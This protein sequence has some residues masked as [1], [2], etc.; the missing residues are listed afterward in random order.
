MSLA[1]GT[2]L[3]PFEIVAPLGAGGMGEVYRAKDTRLGREVAVK[4]LPQHLSSNPEIRAR[5]EREAKTVSSLNHPHICTLHDVG[6]EGETDYLVME[7]IEGET[8]AARLTKGAL[9]LADVLRIGAQIAD[10]LGRAHRAG[11]MHRDLK[12]GNVMLTK[13]G[14]KLMDFGLARATGLGATS[15][16]TSS[17]TVA[18]P[19]TA[20]G[21]ILGTFQYMAPEQLEG[22]EADA[23]AD[24]WALG[25]VLYEMATGRRAFEGATQASLI[26]AIM[27]DTP[28]PMA[29][30]APLSPPA[31]ERVVRHCLAKDPEDRI[32]TAHDVKLQLEGI[33]E[34]GS[35][36]SSVATGQASAAPRRGASS[37][38]RIAWVLVALVT[39]ISAGL[40]FKLS[41]P[42]PHIADAAPMRFTVTAP[43]HA[44]LNTSNNNVSI[45]PNGK[46]LA[47]VASDE[48]GTA[49]IWIRELGGLTARALAGTEN[50]H[51]PF[52]S[53]DGRF[54]GF[55]AGGKLRKIALS[56]G[57][58]E[59]LCDAPDSRGG[60][61]GNGGDIVFAPQATGGLFRVSAEGGEP[62]EVV[63]PDASRK[64]TGLRF[65]QFL[66]DGK[67][68]VFVSMPQRQGSYE[69]FL[70]SLASKDRVLLMRAGAAPVWADPDYLVTM[71]NQRLV[72]QRFDLATGKLVGEP[73][74]LGDAPT[75]EGP[76]GV[77]LVSASRNGILAY[78]ASRL[79]NTQVS[80]FDRAGKRQS[81]LPLAKGRW[82]SVNIAPDGRRALVGKPSSAAELDWW[83]VDLG[84]SSARRLTA[85]SAGSFAV[86]SPTGDR[87]VYQLSTSGPSDIYVKPVEGGGAAEPLVV[88]DVLFKNPSQWTPD[89]KHVTFDQPDPETAWDIWRVPLAG[90]RKP[91]PLVKTTAN[92]HGGWVSPDVRWVAYTSDESGR[93]ELY[94]QSYPVAGQRQQLTTSG[95]GNLYGGIT[96]HWSRDGR[97]LL[98][99][100]GTARVM[101]IAPGSVFK[102]GP[103]RL[104][105]VMPSGVVGFSTTT[106]H[107]RFL[108]V[109]PVA[110]AEPPAI[111]LDLNWAA[112]LE[113]R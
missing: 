45:S 22:K 9:P 39:A 87:I 11:V 103:P 90:E 73:Q 21:T 110:D 91:E 64:E 77:R 65:P 12:P 4:V 30:L 112:G 19:L 108:V 25:C 63:H 72:A 28:R 89:G 50:G 14:A 61:W 46:S 67:Q 80:W 47:F 16:L 78:S 79:S 51:A 70:A 93:D 85:A 52:W 102:A 35:Q 107:Q 84:T 2:R 29:E 3:G 15:E 18:G 56:G 36:Q 34:P 48:N 33:A 58:P 26:S 24:L 83:L 17:P 104:L 66:P 101:D 53:P 60:S 37:R 106:D 40:A 97:E 69:I 99:F 75:I 113:K 82:G 98:L 6:R 54:L 13:S 1:P 43:M 57:S 59:L 20:E 109:E 86:W 55:F 96:V 38:E 71:R 5:F 111:E 100:D 23:R 31:L 88:S 10:A 41:R 105:F 68:F 7:L 32:Q 94:V 81:S 42:A 74:E 76:D 8:L 95:I 49:L 44:R 92:E 62:A 27:R